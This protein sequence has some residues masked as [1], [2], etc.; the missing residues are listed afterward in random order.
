MWKTGV[1]ARTE[2]RSAFDSVIGCSGVP[3]CCDGH[4]LPLCRRC[5]SSVFEVLKHCSCGDAAR[6]LC[7]PSFLLSISLVIHL[8][9]H[10]SLL[11][12]ISLVIHLSCHPS[13][14]S[15]ISLVVPSLLSFHLSCRPSLLVVI[16]ISCRPSLL[17]VIDLSCC[18]SIF[19][20]LSLLSL[21][22]YLSYHASF[23]S[24]ISPIIH[25]SY[26]TSLVSYLSS[27]PSL[28][29]LF[30]SPNV[31]YVFLAIRR[32]LCSEDLMRYTHFPPPS[33]THACHWRKLA[34]CKQMKLI[35]VSS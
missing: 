17:V 30:V 27:R 13:L 7:Y 2:L 33:M 3:L 11:S 1:L 5:V 14:L 16:H 32:F 9:C 4:Y 8:S 31:G 24:C 22:M 29:S 18:P 34:L 12:S 21:V 26:N 20:H 28:F 10:P 15:S 25:R 6:H 35:S 19:C 23:L